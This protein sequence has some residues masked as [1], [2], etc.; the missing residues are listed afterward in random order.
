MERATG[1]GGEG[2]G[3]SIFTESPHTFLLP[4]SQMTYTTESRP[5]RACTAAAVGSCTTPES[6]AAP[7]PTGTAAA[8]AVEGGALLSPAL[9]AISDL[10][11]ALT[12]AE[13]DAASAA[14]CAA[15][16]PV[17]RGACGGPAGT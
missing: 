11:M 8:T 14:A 7:A 1:L 16:L 9:A 13:A 4:A 5:R 17:L 3:L 2:L 12:E 6:P 15:V 10:A